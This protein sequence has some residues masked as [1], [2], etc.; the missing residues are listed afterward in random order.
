LRRKQPRSVGSRRRRIQRRT[1]F[2]D[3]LSFE[4]VDLGVGQTE[5]LG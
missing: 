2:E 3:A 1:L 4:R 5:N